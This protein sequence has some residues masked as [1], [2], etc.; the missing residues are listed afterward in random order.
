MYYLPG[1]TGWGSAFGGCPTA[2]WKPQVQSAGPDFGVVAGKFGF[3]V[4]RASDRTVVV[5]AC[6]NLSHSTW[7]RVRTNTVIG[8]SA[9]FS[10]PQWGDYPARFYRLRS[11]D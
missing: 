3:T 7:T 9:S 11:A 8:G 1:A 10:D 6:A 5:Q 4:S 2:L